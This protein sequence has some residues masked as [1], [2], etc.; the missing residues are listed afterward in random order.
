MYS[1]DVSDAQ[2]ILGYSDVF[3]GE[4]PN[5][6]EKIQK[7]NMHKTIS[8]ISELIQIRDAKCEPIYIWGRE[9][10]FPFEII[11]KWD[12]CG[13]KP[14]SPKEMM[15]NIMLRKN[16]HIISLQMLLILLKKVIIY[17]NYESLKI[18]DYEINDEDYREVIILQLLVAD[19]VSEKHKKD[20]DT[21]HFLYATYHLNYQRNVATEF[22]RMYYMME[23]LSIDSQVFDD[24]IKKEYRKY[25]KDFTSQYGV[26]PTEYSSLLFFELQ[27]YFSEKNALSKSKCWRD[28]D[29]IYK[30]A[31][32]KE[33]ISKVIDILKA[34][35]IKLKEWAEKTEQEEWDFTSFYS[36]PFIF[37]GE[38]DCISISDIT[39]RNGFFEK[40][41]WLI[42]DCYPKE[43]K[44]AMAFFGRLFERYI[45]DATK[46]A[47]LNHYTYIDEFKFQVERNNRKSSDA[48]I[49]KGNDLLVVEAKGFSVLV[50]C[51]AKNEKIDKNNEKL[52]IKPVLQADECLSKSFDKKEEFKGVE[53]AFIVSV[54][55]DN[56]NAVPN[57]YNAIHKEINENKKCDLVHY[58]FNFSIEEYEMLLYLVEQGI[59]I[60]S[61]LRGYFTKKTLEP[62]SNYLREKIPVISMT[63]FMERNYKAA[64]DK[65]KS[66]L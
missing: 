41:F 45:Q 4:K 36:F 30:D 52:F 53:E 38:S 17:G 31:K 14:E 37:D 47:S 48:Y 12:Y 15:E 60:F 20:I 10:E 18:R 35:P 50:D 66:I 32:E 54:T 34:E 19:D 25:Y 22:L 59:D 49:R 23:C 6:I 24:D 2:L 55:L 27:Y 65:M 63:R 39:L 61:I 9:V 5:F 51:I 58:Y 46:D 16:Q 57:Y 3:A 21:D 33:K 28:T 8:I 43:D 62:F 1:V 40:I 42:R 13:M 29:L 11:L 44:H 56:I 64:T 7:M 26:T